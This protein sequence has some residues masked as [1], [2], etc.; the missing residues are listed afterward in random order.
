MYFFYIFFISKKK[1]KM[2]DSS[3]FSGGT[4]QI[5]H[6]CATPFSCNAN[7]RI[8]LSCLSPLSCYGPN[9]D[10]PFLTVWQHNRKETDHC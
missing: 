7:H 8:L 2:C 1:I 9:N 5:L 6:T 4:H 3:Q 10:M